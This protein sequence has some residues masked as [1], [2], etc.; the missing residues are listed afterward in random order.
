MEMLQQSLGT[1]H[2]HVKT[3]KKSLAYRFS[4]WCQSQEK[5]RLA[6][7][8]GI[9]FGHGCII[10][11]LTLG[12]VIL[13]G[14]NFVFWPWVIAAIGMSLVANLAAL[15][16]KITIPAFFLSLLIDLVVIVY[17]IVTALNIL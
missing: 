1:I 10:T 2:L 6:W 12:F 9:I 4:D 13:T 8:A 3:K 7:L 15:P 17:C 5:N 11:P 16:T 14:N